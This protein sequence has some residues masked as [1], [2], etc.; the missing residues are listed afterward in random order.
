VVADALPDGGTIASVL[1]DDGM[2]IDGVVTKRA[3][4]EV[5]ELGPPVAGGDGTLAGDE[6]ERGP[7]TPLRSRPVAS[8]R[9]VQHVGSW[10]LIALAQQHGLHQDAERLAGGDA[11]RIALDATLAALAIGERTVEGVR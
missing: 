8:G 5:P 10:L 7:V 11:T 2:A 6:R 4:E 9:L 1:A 3:T